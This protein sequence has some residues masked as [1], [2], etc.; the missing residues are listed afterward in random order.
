MQAFGDGFDLYTI[1][2]DSNGYWEGVSAGNFTVQPGRFTGGQALQF[3]TGSGLFMAKTSGANDAVHHI[4]VSFMQSAA[5]S[6]STI[7]CYIQLADGATNQCAIVFR[8]DGAILLQSGTV[9]GTTLATYTGAFPFASTWYAFEIEVVINNTTGSLT[10]RTNG[11]PSNSFTATGLNTRGG[12]ANNYANR[13]GIGASSFVSSWLI[14][15]FLWRS[16]PTSVPWVGDI[17]CYTRMPGTDISIQFARG[18]GSYN[19]VLQASAVNA[20]STTAN[21][22]YFTPFVCP[23]GTTGSIASLGIN[24]N[25]GYTG[26]VNMAIYDATGTGGAPGN[27]VTNGTATAITTPI[28]NSLVFTFAT[29]PVLTR[30]STYWAALNGDV[31]IQWLG[32]PNVTNMYSMSQ[33]YASGFPSSASSATALAAH[34]GMGNLNMNAVP[35]NSTLVGEAHQDGATTYVFDSTVNDADFYGFPALSGVVPPT[36]VICIGVRGY[37]QKSDAGARTAA[38]QL[39]SGATTVAT[40]TL[41]LSTNWLWTGSYYLNDPNTSAAWTTTAVNNAQI[42]PLVVS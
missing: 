32:P 26:H 14:D 34:N 11:A 37:M 13:I 28:T 38:M 33:S 1:F 18:Q 15:D 20:G 4:V 29:P 8:T 3:Q 5:I 42:G 30:G 12:T 7:G 9:G 25:T 41:S 35:L 21:I 10:V 31:S 24:L 2:L 40:P 16:D 17:R 27:L 39:K 36:S 6:G 22:L 19:V 23:S